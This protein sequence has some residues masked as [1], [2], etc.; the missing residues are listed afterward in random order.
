MAE[1]TVNQLASCTITD[2]SEARIGPIQRSFTMWSNQMHEA[3]NEG[4]LQKFAD[5]AEFARADLDDFHR[6]EKHQSRNPD[7]SGRTTPFARSPR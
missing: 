2:E 1:N 5:A 7:W 3:R 4:N 6:E